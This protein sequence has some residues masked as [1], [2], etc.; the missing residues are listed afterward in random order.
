MTDVETIFADDRTRPPPERSLPWPETSGGVTVIIE[1]KPHWA[2]DLRAF[3]LDAKEYCTYS[4]W[5]E[6]GARARFFEH[7]DTSGDTVM[8]R[9]RAVLAREIAD[10]LWN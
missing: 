2:G 1:P 6:N 9:A 7:V 10:G 5:T 3:R 8:R 4:D